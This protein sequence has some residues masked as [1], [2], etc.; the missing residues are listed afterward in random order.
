MSLA[1]ALERAAEA[2]PEHADAIRPANG[3]PTRLLEQLDAEAG[4]RVL[5]WLLAQEEEAGAELALAW[6]EDPKGAEPLRRAGEAELPK[7]ARKALRRALH[8]LRGRGVVVAEPP[9]A[10][11][12]A[13]LPKLEGALEGAFV[14]ALDPT[15]ARLAY[16]VEP[17]P[18]GGARI[19]EIVL[20][21]ERGI[22]D[23]SAY[24]TARGPARRFLREIASR[25]RFPALA[26]PSEAL[27]ALVARAAAAATTDRPLPRAFL[28][29]R[30]RVAAPAPGARTPGELA[31]EAL[32]AEA[33]PAA[34]RRA[35]EL[36]ESGEIGP[37]PPAEAVLRRAGERIQ[38]AV[39]GR[40]IVSGAQQGERVDV[41]LH[42]V[43]GEVFDAAGA[44]RNAARLE[45]AAYL[46]WK[47]GREDDARACLGAARA[48]REG[49]ASESALARALLEVALAPVLAA[50]REEEKSSLI[51]KP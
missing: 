45:E 12:V 14:S 42:E 15:G 33:S 36:V 26:V 20:D 28:E 35:A 17:N 34:S 44:E 29:W 2:L 4:G 7:P 3:D 40:I 18:A 9:P 31:R 41:A 10:P 37:W 19:F 39:R 25:A 11:L 49:P 38:E 1:D 5:A 30:S 23:F 32:R 22:L 27:R 24:S 13:V 16:L 51:V 6:A 48:L 47:Q 46:F 8:R 43:L 21:D 50:L